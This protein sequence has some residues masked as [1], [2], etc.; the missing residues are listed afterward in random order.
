MPKGQPGRSLKQGNGTRY[1]RDVAMTLTIT[2]A[3]TCYLLSS[4]IFSALYVRFADQSPVAKTLRKH[5]YL[6]P[7]IPIFVFMYLLKHAMT[8]LIRIP[9]K[10]TRRAFEILSGKKTYKKS[11]AYH[12]Y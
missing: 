5:F 7:F 12:K 2:I 8:L 9:G 11:S 4:F 10:M 1:L 3:S 6:F